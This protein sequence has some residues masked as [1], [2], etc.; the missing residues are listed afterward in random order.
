MWVDTLFGGCGV[1]QAPE[2]YPSPVLLIAK[3]EWGCFMLEATLDKPSNASP[4]SCPRAWLRRT[5]HPRF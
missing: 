3:V 5:C 1:R 4:D 2:V